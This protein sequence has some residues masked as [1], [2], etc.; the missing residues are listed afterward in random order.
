MNDRMTTKVLKTH[1]H[2]GAASPTKHVIIFEHV[3]FKS[4]KADKNIMKRPAHNYS[5]TYKSADKN[6]KER[7]MLV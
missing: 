5:I 4:Y 1:P 2:V 3:Y 6:N 7:V